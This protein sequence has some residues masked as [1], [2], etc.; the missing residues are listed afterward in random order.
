[1]RKL[2][3]APEQGAWGQVEG[4]VEP[5]RSEPGPGGKRREKGKRTTKGP[6]AA[7]AVHEGLQPYGVLTG[8]QDSSP[9][10]DRTSSAPRRG[11]GE[12]GKGGDGGSGSRGMEILS[13]HT[14]LVFLDPRRIIDR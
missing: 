9:H 13:F 12:P 6:L 11:R 7:P 10:H 14:L 5:A 4:E 1:V 8:S 2:P 3:P